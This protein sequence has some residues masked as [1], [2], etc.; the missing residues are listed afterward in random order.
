MNSVGSDE[1]RNRC[2]SESK[3]IIW[4]DD[5]LSS[6]RDRVLLSPLE[7]TIKKLGFQI[8]TASSQSEFVDVLKR[9]EQEPELISGILLDMML[10]RHHDESHWTELG[11]PKVEIQAYVAGRQVLEFFALREYASQAPTFVAA[12]RLH[13]IAMLTAA[14]QELVHLNI[15]KSKRKKY[16][17]IYKLSHDDSVDF[18]RETLPVDENE[19]LVGWLERLQSNGFNKAT[20]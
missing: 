17:L 10:T 3:R 18:T 9:Y 6:A 5:H 14:R 13:S 12:F 7:E 16:P 15:P 19:K 8:E 11:F 1:K 2:K 4:Y 20:I